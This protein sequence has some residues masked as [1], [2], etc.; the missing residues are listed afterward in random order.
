MTQISTSDQTPSPD[1]DRTKNLSSLQARLQ[2]KQLQEADAIRQ[3]TENALKAHAASLKT[4]SDDALHTMRSVTENAIQQLQSTLES[5][6]QLSKNDIQQ[7]LKVGGQQIHDQ[8]RTVI[9]GLDEKHLQLQSTLNQ[10]AEALTAATAKMTKAVAHTTA[11]VQKQQT[12]LRQ[13]I[14]TNTEELKEQLESNNRQLLWLLKMPLMALL[15]VCLTLF[16]STLAWTAYQ[17][18]DLDRTLAEKHQE[19]SRVQ[20]QINQLTT[21]FCRSPAGQGRC[22]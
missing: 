22:R 13:Q 19:L 2:Q 10:G 15:A 20:T 9:A 12:T 21:E 8:A 18:H 16:G 4:L 14:E 6:L 17:V 5:T 7:A 3:Q 1:S 11:T